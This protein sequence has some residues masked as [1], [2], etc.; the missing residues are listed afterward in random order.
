MR[1][2]FFVSLLAISVVATAQNTISP[3]S[4][5]VRML[6]DGYSLTSDQLATMA[7]IQTR[8]T[9]NLTELSELEVKDEDAYFER[10]KSVYQHTVQSIRQALTKEQRISFN[11]AQ[12]ERRIAIREQAKRLM[13]EGKSK[14]EIE[15][16][17]L[18][19]F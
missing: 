8:H 17:L 15:R 9:R 18:E 10:R 7:E 3:T 16:I 11:E 19:Q 6:V 5:L 2:I 12:K 4:D 1:I 13:A 14:L